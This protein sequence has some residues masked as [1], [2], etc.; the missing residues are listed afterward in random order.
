MKDLK[1]PIAECQNTKKFVL[2]H[3]A[4]KNMGPFVCLACNGSLCLRKE[5]KTRRQHFAHTSKSSKTCESNETVLHWTAKHLLAIYCSSFKFVQICYDCQ[6]TI[7]HKYQNTLIN[8]FTDMNGECEYSIGSKRVDVAYLDV[9]KNIQAIIEVK[10]T[11]EVESEKWIYLQKL[12]PNIMFYEV[13]A[14]TV[15]ESF[16]HNFK[17]SVEYWKP[18]HYKCFKCYKKYTRKCHK[19]NKYVLIVDMREHSRKW[20]CLSC[21]P[22][23]CYFCDGFGNYLGDDCWYCDDGALKDSFSIKECESKKRKFD[24]SEM[25]TQKICKFC[26]SVI[27]NE[28][29]STSRV[30]LMCK[31]K[32]L[33][34]SCCSQEFPK[35]MLTEMNAMLLC[36]TCQMRYASCADCSKEFLKLAIGQKDQQ[37]VCPPCKFQCCNCSQKFHESNMLKINDRIMCKQCRTNFVP[38]VHCLKE[39]HKL[40][41]TK[42]IDGFA[43]KN[44]EMWCVNCIVC[45]SKFHQIDDKL[46]CQICNF[47]K[48]EI[49]AKINDGS[50]VFICKIP[51]TH[52]SQ[53]SCLGCNF[54][55]ISKQWIVTGMETFECQKWIMN[56]KEKNIIQLLKQERTK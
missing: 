7:K 14:L 21:C 35:S 13:L 44:C 24:N 41:M 27:D 42:I 30:C 19:C 25:I 2:A 46:L 37:L 10:V 6:E 23:I 36:K 15:I 51:P 56:D 12:Y 34:C 8:Q 54:N 48:Q 49:K 26:L 38:C 32:Y 16:K 17:E 4:T 3:I 39:S 5:S 50:G 9:S 11:H 47:L 20:F 40:T 29:D 18:D 28:F 31:S 22:T 1:I 45:S 53:A 43:C 55:F 33:Q 52:V